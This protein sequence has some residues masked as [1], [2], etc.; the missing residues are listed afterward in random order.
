MDRRT[1]SALATAGLLAASSAAEAQTWRTM[2]S[3]RQLHDRELTSVQIEYG[4][5]ELTVEP[6]PASMLYEMELRFDEDEFE[7]ITEYDPGERTL[8]LGMD[9]RGRGGMMN[10]KSGSRAVIGLSREAPLDLDLDFGAGEAELDLS[11]MRI[12]RLDISTGASETTVRFDSPNPIAAEH[13]RIDAG[14]AELTVV[15]L[16][17]ARA[18]SIDFQGGVGSTTLDFTGAWAADA[19]ASVHMGIG[20]LTLRF[21]RGLAVKLEKSSFLSSFDTQGLIKRGDAFYSPDWD[22]A[23]HRLSIDVNTAFGTVDVEWVG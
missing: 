8:R 5:G 1:I 10:I 21:P 15:G 23:A 4:A 12:R 16:G 2:E 22:T 20:E 6:A 17:N 18:R 19:R 13:V 14:A 11:G 3:A 7:P 9:G